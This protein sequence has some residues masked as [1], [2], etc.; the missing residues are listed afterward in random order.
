MLR[1]FAYPVWFV[2]A[3]VWAVWF[4]RAWRY[5]H[6]GSAKWSFFLATCIAV[7]SLA[8][9]GSLIS[10]KITGVRGI[11]TAVYTGAVVVVA[12]VL[13]F[14]AARAWWK[15]LRKTNGKS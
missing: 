3:S 5:Q 12:L 15:A 2:G 11:W 1:F 4:Y 13:A 7:F 14:G 9:F 6:C 10:L 8:T